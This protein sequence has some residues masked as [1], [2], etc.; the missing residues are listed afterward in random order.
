MRDVIRMFPSTTTLPIVLSIPSCL[1]L[2][3][4][5][6]FFKTCLS[7]VRPRPYIFCV[8]SGR[9][10]LYSSCAICYDP[11]VSV[12]IA[13]PAPLPC[14]CISPSHDFLSHCFTIPSQACRY[15]CT[16][17]HSRLPSQSFPFPYPKVLGCSFLGSSRLGTKSS[18][19]LLCYSVWTSHVTSYAT[20]IRN[21]MIFK[22]V[23]RHYFLRSEIRSLGCELDILGVWRPRCSLVWE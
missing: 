9:T 16:P 6:S 21:V 7:N 3:I 8:V 10:N 12:S 17:L 13:R 1:F 4:L 14:K 19:L 15:L 20:Y 5:F 23:V 11:F 2:D 22:Q 18:P